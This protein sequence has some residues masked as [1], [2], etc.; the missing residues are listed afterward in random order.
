LSSV[1][2]KNPFK[3]KRVRQAFY[4]AIDIEAIKTRVMRGTST[5]TALMV[6][7]AVNGFVP[8]LNKRLPYNTDAAKRLLAEAGYPNGFELG[9]NC[10]N[11]RY[12]NDA[13]ICQAVAGM[14]ARIGVKINLMAETKAIFFPKALRREV[15]FYMLGWTPD[16]LDAHNAMFALMTTP[17]EGG[18]GQFNLGA[19]SNPRFDELTS[20]VASE[21]NAAKRQ[22]MI[23]EAFKLHADDI[24]HLPLHQQPL[25]WG[26]KK[27]VGVVLLANNFNYLKWVVIK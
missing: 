14:L 23:A 21:N 10:P 8:E 17:A 12:V 1:K 4:Q 11:D 15:S 20:K 18:Q 22:A 13:E 19:Y 25:V 2:G 6:A 7:P 5:P 26:M 9:M 16:S 3:D 24:G 27:N